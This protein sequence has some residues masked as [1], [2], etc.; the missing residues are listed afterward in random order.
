MYRQRQL[1]HTSLT[2][3]TLATSGSGFWVKF[4]LEK[5]HHGCHGNGTAIILLDLLRWNHTILEIYHCWI[6]VEE[7]TSIVT[8]R[9][10]IYDVIWWIKMWWSHLVRLILNKLALLVYFYIYIVYTFKRTVWA[11]DGRLPWQRCIWRS[12]RLW[13][14]TRKDNNVAFVWKNVSSFAGSLRQ[15]VRGRKTTAHRSKEVVYTALLR[16][17]F[18]VTCIQR[19]YTM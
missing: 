13:N 8:S 19:L 16:H 11:M 5:K 10:C 14:L 9:G 1:P 12:W 17:F 4:D 15:G 7:V 18:G 3:M 6:F 2:L